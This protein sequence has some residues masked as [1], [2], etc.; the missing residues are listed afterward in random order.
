MLPAS[1]GGDTYVKRALEEAE[2]ATRQVHVLV[3]EDELLIRMFVSDALRDE[4]YSVIEAINA[5]EALDIVMAGKAVDIVFSD[6]RMPEKLYGL[7]LL[8]A[9]KDIYPM[10]PVILASGHLGYKD[11]LAEGATHIISKP[12]QIETVLRLIANGLVQAE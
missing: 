2:T 10:V 11:A 1:F 9:L 3:V 12:Y 5:E 8:N 7:G 4:G 6:V